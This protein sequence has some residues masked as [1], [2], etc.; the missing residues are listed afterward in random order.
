MPRLCPVFHALIFVIHAP[1]QQ[2]LAVTQ[3]D[4]GVICQVRQVLQL[5]GIGFQTEEDVRELRVSK[6]DVF[7]LPVAHYPE[8]MEIRKLQGWV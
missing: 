1:A 2:L 3:L 6:V 7:E 8:E 4:R 5:V